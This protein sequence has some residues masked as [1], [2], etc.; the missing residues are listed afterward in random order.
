MKRRY[1]IHNDGL[2]VLNL[3]AD[4]AWKALTPAV[5]ITDEVLSFD[6]ISYFSATLDQAQVDKLKAAGIDFKED[7]ARPATLLIDPIYE[8]QRIG[9]NK[10]AKQN[11]TGR[12][13]KV[14]VIDSGC[15]FPEWVDH[16]VNLA[17]EDPGISDGA[18]HGTG[19]TSIIHGPMGLAVGCELHHIKVIKNNGT[20][21]EASMLSAIDYCI[22]QEIDIVVMSFSFHTAEFQAAVEVMAAGQILVAASSGNST[23]LDQILPPAYYEG[24]LAINA[25]KADGGP[26]YK[27]VQVPPGG[28][29]GITFACSG[30]QTEHIRADGE[31]WLAYGASYSAPFFAGVFAL[32]H[33][34][35][36]RTSTNQTIL[37]HIKNK[38]IRQS[39]DL[40]FGYGIPTL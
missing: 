27:S 17:D 31:P 36:A 4:Q 18:Q 9:W 20:V 8:K 11:I 16:A 32:Y 15:N 21:T 12:G 37:Q 26:H 24:V 10:K 3:H 2:A 39:S 13:C 6:A 7:V 34:E 14:A 40:Y 30:Y 22:E 5:K 28:T 25:I 35:Y 19:V 33:E 38:A 29:H 23:T 1:T